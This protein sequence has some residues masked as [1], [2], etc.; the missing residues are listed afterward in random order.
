MKK[1]IMIS[2][3]TCFVINNSTFGMLLKRT[4]MQNIAKKN[5]IL[6]KQY[7]SRTQFNRAELLEQLEEQK[8]RFT[9]EQMTLLKTMIT[10]STEPCEPGKT[11]DRDFP[12]GNMN[13][14]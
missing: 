3:I 13:K 1:I 9:S 6:A 5:S 10:N 14:E 8:H 11:K 4:F 2:A 7:N 12:Q